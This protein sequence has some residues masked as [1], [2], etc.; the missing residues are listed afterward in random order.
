LELPSSGHAI[1]AKLRRKVAKVLE[2]MR[3]I[4]CKMK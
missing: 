1:R 3:S 4:R 2:R